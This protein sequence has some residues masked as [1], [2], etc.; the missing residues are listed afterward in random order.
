MGPDPGLMNEKLWDEAS[1]LCFDKPSQWILIHA[2]TLRTTVL[3][4]RFPLCFFCHLFVKETVS[5]A[6]QTFLQP[7]LRWLHPHSTM[8]HAFPFLDFC[9]QVRI[10]RPDHNFWQEYFTGGTTW[11][12]KAQDDCLHDKD[13]SVVQMLQTYYIH[14]RLFSPNG[15]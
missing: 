15:F 5:F 3:I 1:N 7:G 13:G 4:H 2:S 6:S 12:Q 8:Q 10:W 9:K 14:F 11:G